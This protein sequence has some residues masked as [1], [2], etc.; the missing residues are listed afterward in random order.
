MRY[1]WNFD[2]SILR[3]RT[4]FSFSELRLHKIFSERLV[5]AHLIKAYYPFHV[6]NQVTTKAGNV[7][8]FILK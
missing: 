8:H 2:A 4:K 1:L 5:L 6:R 7:L 3:R